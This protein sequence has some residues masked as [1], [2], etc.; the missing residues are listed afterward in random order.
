[1]ETEDTFADIM[2]AIYWDKQANTVITGPR[3]LEVV[4]ERIT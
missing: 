1:M 3:S 2:I 4:D